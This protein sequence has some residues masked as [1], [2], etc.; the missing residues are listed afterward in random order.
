MSKY[1]ISTVSTFFEV[2]NIAT[3]TTVYVS[4]KRSKVVEICNKLNLGQ[5]SEYD[6]K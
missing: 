1:K 3:M 6:L 5:L 4:D 2:F